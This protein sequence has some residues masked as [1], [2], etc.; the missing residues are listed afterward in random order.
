MSILSYSSPSLTPRDELPATTRQ[1]AASLPRPAPA[2]NGQDLLDVAT[3]LDTRGLVATRLSALTPRRC[4]LYSR[5]RS[6]SGKV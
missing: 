5:T 2:V 4:E 6:K 3:G 1:S